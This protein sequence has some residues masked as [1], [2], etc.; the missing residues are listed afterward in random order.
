MTLRRTMTTLSVTALLV[1]GCSTTADSPDAAVMSGNPASDSG[2]WPDA[3]PVT[4]T[5]GQDAGV[6]DTG[7]VDDNNDSFAE[8][9]AVMVGANARGAINPPGDD[10]Y[11]SFQA[12][13]GDWVSIFTVANPQTMPDMVDTV[14]T[15]YD[16]QM[17]QIAENDDGLPRVSPDSEIIYHVPAAGTYFVKVQEFSAWSGEPPE[18]RRSYTYELRLRALVAANNPFVVIDTEAGDGVQGALPLKFFQGTN[19]VV[20]GTFRDGSDVDVYQLTVAQPLR[21]FDAVVMPAGS[22]GYGSTTPAGNLWLTTV[23]GSTITARVDNGNFQALQAP[24]EAGQYLLWVGH[25]GTAV[26]ANDHYVL[27]TGLLQE[28]APELE[29]ATNGTLATA[30]RVTLA[31]DMPRR[32]FILPRLPAGDVDYYAF[33]MMAGEQ[34][35]VAC[36]GQRTGSGIRDLSVEVRDLND[37]V[38]ASGTETATTGAALLQLTVTATTNYLRLSAGSQD[39]EVAGDYLRCGI[40]AFIP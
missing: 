18:G 16:S 24:V 6:R 26:G 27:K 28:N 37:T 12:N 30:E 20:L 1:G 3:Q 39:P 10:D 8:A 15:L 22:D 34:L 36:S 31:G 5:G 4:D 13:A 29:E 14:I 19:G 2:V 21:R 33:S 17:T 9:E 11:F 23:D 25:P 38:I 35:S 32:G 7:P 40:Q